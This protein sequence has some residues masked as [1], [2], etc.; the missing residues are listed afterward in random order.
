[1]HIGVHLHPDAV[2]A[3]RGRAGESRG[4]ISF[5]GAVLGPGNTSRGGG[6]GGGAREGRF[7]PEIGQLRVFIHP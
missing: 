2:G 5:G 7:P 6:G 3:H 1:M 4:N